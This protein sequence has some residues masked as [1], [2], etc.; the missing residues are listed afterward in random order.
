M[1]DRLISSRGMFSL[2]GKSS[3]EKRHNQSEKRQLR[4]RVLKSRVKSSTKD[5]LEAV[6]AKEADAAQAKYKILESIID[7]ATSKGTLHRNTGARKKARL[8]RK[9][10]QLN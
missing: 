7:R 9:L 2:T 1:A 10:Q 4:N 6:S 3:A 5:F 8:Y